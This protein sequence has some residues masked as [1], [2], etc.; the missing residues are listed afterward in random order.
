MA[1][2]ASSFSVPAQ[3]IC[4]P[5][6]HGLQFGEM[7]VYTV[8][9][10][11]ACS[12]SCLCGCVCERICMPLLVA[13]LKRT[14]KLVLTQGSDGHECLEQA[15]AGN[16]HSVISKSDADNI[17]KVPKGDAQPAEAGEGLVDS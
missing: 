6:F 8:L 4:L 1:V 16:S 14:A 13:Y 2:F 3:C 9:C 15:E 10:G 5:Q 12:R 7:C 11:C 17:L